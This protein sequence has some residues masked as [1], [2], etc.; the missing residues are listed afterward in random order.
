MAK[1]LVIDIES[2]AP[3][4]CEFESYQAVWI[5]FYEEAIQQA[6]GML[7]VFTQVPTCA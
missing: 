2:L 3:H 7:V 5:L 4:R 1:W 6:Y